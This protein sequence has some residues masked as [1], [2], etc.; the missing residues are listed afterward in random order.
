MSVCLL[1]VI[2]FVCLFVCLFVGVGVCLFVC[3]FVPLVGRGVCLLVKPVDT[4]L[5]LR[6]ARLKQLPEPC[7]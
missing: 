5:V 3:L 7:F 1:G 2:V 6:G 4:Y